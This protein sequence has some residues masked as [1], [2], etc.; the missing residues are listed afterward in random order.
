M[1]H[2]IALL[3]SPGTGKST[4]GL[5]YP[6]VEQH[7][8]GSSEDTTAAN[9]VGRT[10]ILPA[11][12]YDWYDTLTPEEQAKL[13]DEKVNELEIALL[14]KKARAKNVARYRRYLYSLKAAKL[15][16][17][18]PE[19]QSILLDN[20]TPFSQEF[21][22]YVEVVWGKEFLTK[23]GNFDTIAYY[24][25]F[26]SE[27]SDFLRLFMSINCH[28]IIT[29]HVAMLASEEVAANTSFM[30]AAKTGGIRK[31]WQPM[32]TGKARNILSAIPDWAF[33]LK[34][35]ESPGLPTKYV[36]K[37]ES[38]EANVGVAKPRI[39]PFA[40]PRRIEFPKNRFYEVFSEAL[41]TY[42]K[43]GIAVKNPGA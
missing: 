32:I 1:L 41:E 23:E 31:E 8:W 19:L 40:N 6:G 20:F 38:D 16:E 25:R 18:R 37:L 7:C 24:K 43:T 4:M 17:A 5:S 10:D 22:D 2:K 39:Q 21:E 34:V 9:F 14:T 42:A 33:F 28:T 11:I 3:G 29:C 27:L 30:T 13:S 35:E 12:R 15:S 36:A 26:A